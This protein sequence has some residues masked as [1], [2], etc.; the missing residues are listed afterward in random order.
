MTGRNDPCPCGSGKKFKKCCEAKQANAATNTCNVPA[1][2]KRLLD[3]V[4]LH[5]A[6]HLDAAETVYRE[7]LARVPADSNA[8]HYLGLI[9]FQRHR[10]AEAVA[11][12]KQ[13]IQISPRTPG[14]FCNLGNA[15]MGL[16]QYEE[17]RESYQK[18]ATLDSQFA[19]AHIGV[20]KALLACGQ[21]AQAVA[22]ARRA[23]ACA[24]KFAEAW[25][26]LGDALLDEELIDEAE[27]CYRRVSLLNPASPSALTKRANVLTRF[28]RLNDAQD[29]LT[30]AIKCDA[31]YEPAYSARLMNLTYLSS[32]QNQIF[33]LHRDWAQR[34]V[35]HDTVR[36]RRSVR[37]TDDRRIRIGY[38]SADF[39]RHALR[40]F[41]RPI[42]RYHDRSRFEVHCYYNYASEDEATQQIKTLAE[43]WID[44]PRLSDEDLYQR[45]VA[46]E[47]DILVDLSGHT[48]GHRLKV[49]ALKP[50]PVQ[51]TMLG[52][53]NT[54]GLCAIDYRVVDR[55]TCPP[56]LFEDDHSEK[57]ARLPDCQWCYEPDSEPLI[58]PLPAL[59]NGYATFG[60][61][62][63][64]AKLTQAQIALF[65]D[66]LC[67]S[68]QARLLM[69]VWGE[70]PRQQLLK[71][72]AKA[73]V[74]ERVRIV[75][76]RAYQDYLALYDQ[77]DVSLD[78]SPYSGGTTSMESL[79]LGVP[80]VTMRGNTPT[81]NGGVS[82][83]TTAGLP[84]LI[85]DSPQAYVDIACRLA[86]DI[87]RMN[88]LRKS[89]RPRL[90]ASPIMDAARYVRALESLFLE[91]MA[92]AQP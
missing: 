31:G 22:A 43:H 76:P 69:V 39:R 51:A 65:A 64:L 71:V 89:L 40:F 15:Q 88:L 82:I 33:R 1:A 74:A 47:I 11:L 77:I 60:S 83:L 6:G 78:A 50:A 32:D 45:I 70:A 34:F 58:G 91:F 59:A 7:I 41:I 81:A 3:A 57:L 56:G 72:F 21:S 87:D 92:R 38:V 26:V 35:A 19:V 24:P 4:A 80:L 36:A 48:K 90:K 62:H 27:G 79:W 73:G 67:Q 66:I 5:Q 10:H 84:E 52:Y 25:M 63:N 44:C 68:P 54:T 2:S 61:F 85:A 42:L 16:Q 23:V 55:H 14:F 29:C 49:F 28:G 20:G 86:S 75:E 53:L 8:L 30:Q 12:I 46:D 9:A 18:A 37:T 17:A 13:A